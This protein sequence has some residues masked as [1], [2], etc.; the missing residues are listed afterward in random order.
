MGPIPKNT[1]YL[2][3]SSHIIGKVYIVY[4]VWEIIKAKGRG[5]LLWQPLPVCL[6][7]VCLGAS[8]LGWTAGGNIKVSQFVDQ[9]RER[10]QKRKTNIY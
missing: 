1:K 4:E 9:T 5:C 6:G 10:F 7:G 2:Q 3:G 8:M